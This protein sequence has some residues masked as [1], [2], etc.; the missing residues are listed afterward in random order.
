MRLHT[1]RLWHALCSTYRTGYYYGRSRRLT[2]DLISNGETQVIVN[3]R[4]ILGFPGHP[5]TSAGAAS[6]YGSFGLILDFDL[7]TG[8]IT[9]IK[10]YYGTPPNYVAANT[11]SAELDPS[12]V[13]T[14]DA[15]T[16]TIKIKYWMNQPSVIT[17]HRTA[18]DETW[19]YSGDR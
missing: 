6:Y 8:K 12:G 9:A 1:A 4:D 17:P 7:A 18:F 14:Y 3:D 15:A 16:K 2:F 5:I 11:R 13:N 10:N 19:V